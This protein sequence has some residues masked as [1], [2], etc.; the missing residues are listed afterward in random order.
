[1][2]EYGVSGATVTEYVSHDDD[3][4]YIAMVYN[5]EIG[6]LQ[7]R[8]NGERNVRY[9][10][11][12]TERKCEF[13]YTFSTNTELSSATLSSDFS[14]GFK[15][16]EYQTRARKQIDAEGTVT[17][18]TFELKI[19]KAA[20]KRI[21]ELDSVDWFGCYG[22][23]QTPDSKRITNAGRFQNT[24]L[25]ACGWGTSSSTMCTAYG[26][27]NSKYSSQ[28]RV[29]NIIVLNGETASET[30]PL[31]CPAENCSVEG[32]DTRRAAKFDIADMRCLGHQT[33]NFVTKKINPQPVIPTTDGVVE[34]G[35][36]TNE[37]VYAK[38]L[39]FSNGCQP[40]SG[41]TVTEYVS[42]DNDYVYIALVFTQ[43]VTNVQI[44]MNASADVVEDLKKLWQPQTALA[45][46]EVAKFN[47]LDTLLRRP[48]DRPRYYLLL[49]DANSSK[50]YLKANLFDQTGA[51]VCLYRWWI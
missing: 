20:M 9:D 32:H 24:G 36:Y 11:P 19:S 45:L 26:L 7:L 33:A 21:F 3:Y 50:T 38:A 15:D 44:M 37:K 43:N 8:I 40:D 5:V 47:Y 25:T 51:L 14:D 18:T 28:M 35:E 42:H 1:M 27:D 6:T 39:H 34:I 13:K 2:Y 10:L 31:Y 4:I 49:P 22:Y 17:G 12:E 29:T 30:I 48:N 23:A 41:A 46:F 16:G